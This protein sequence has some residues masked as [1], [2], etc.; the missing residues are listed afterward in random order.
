M[1]RKKKTALTSV[2]QIKEADL[3]KPKVIRDETNPYHFQKKIDNFIINPTDA[4]LSEES[5]KLGFSSTAKKFL[6]TNSKDLRG[7][8]T[9][10]PSNRFAQLIRDYQQAFI[11]RMEIMGLGNPN[12]DETATREEKQKWY[13]QQDEYVGRELFRN[14][15]YEDFIAFVDGVAITDYWQDRIQNMRPCNSADRTCRHDCPFLGTD[16]CP[17]GVK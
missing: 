11:S 15:G 1:A 13:M 8:Q 3:I 6:A 2:Q 12:N 9:A 14:N 16:N 5:K 17:G 7:R 10:G 4:T